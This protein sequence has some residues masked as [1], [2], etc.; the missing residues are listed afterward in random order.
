MLFFTVQSTV[1]NS[2]ILSCKDKRSSQFI[3]RVGLTSNVLL[4]RSEGDIT[5]EAWDFSVNLWYVAIIKRRNW[6]SLFPVEVLFQVLV[7]ISH[8]A[9]NSTRNVL[10]A[11]VKPLMSRQPYFILYQKPIKVEVSLVM[12]CFSILYLFTYSCNFVDCLIF[13]TR[14]FT[15]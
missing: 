6:I 1:I 2:Y 12:R 11:I 14:K 4:I 9:F 5:K 7:S 8:S 15:I 13:L 10:F 3:L